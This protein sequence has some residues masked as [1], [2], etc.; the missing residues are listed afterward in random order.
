MRARLELADW[1]MIV[2]WVA[3]AAAF[4][5]VACTDAFGAERTG[6]AIL[7]SDMPQGDRVFLY[8]DRSEFCEAVDVGNARGGKRAVYHFRTNH[9]DKRLAGKNVEGCYALRDGTQIMLIF[10]N[11]VEADLAITDFHTPKPPRPAA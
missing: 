9:P 11:G 3:L 2:A 6:A 4:A 7:I 8:S 1:I 5:Y 10:V